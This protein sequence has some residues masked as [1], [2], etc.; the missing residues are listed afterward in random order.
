MWLPLVRF[1]TLA[2][3]PGLF[4]A[5]SAGAQDGPV[6][7]DSVTALAQRLA[8]Q[9]YKDVPS[10]EGDMRQLSYDHYRALRARSDKALWGGTK[11]LFHVEFIPAGFIYEKPVKISIV[12]HGK[13]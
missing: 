3:L 7:F 6:T 4:L 9:P 10:I 8:A 13:E 12:D 5:A 1:I 11:S 2:F